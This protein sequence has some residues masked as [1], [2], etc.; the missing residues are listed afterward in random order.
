MLLRC[1]FNSVVVT[2]YLY[3]DGL[4]CVYLLLGCLMLC[5]L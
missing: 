1:G 5:L 2:H 3:V 4:C